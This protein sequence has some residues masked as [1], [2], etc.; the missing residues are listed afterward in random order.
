[1]NPNF[2]IE[3][4]HV[5]QRQLWEL[6]ATGP[7]SYNATTGDVLNLPNTQYPSC[8]PGGFLT[9]SGTYELKP[10]PSPSTVANIRCTWAFR[11]YVVATGAEVAGAVD[12]SAEVVQ[13]F[14]IGGEM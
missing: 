11:W 13:F 6:T 3:P 1:M 4:T 12:L 5:I 7:K 2:V 9:A 14:V 10:F 8:V